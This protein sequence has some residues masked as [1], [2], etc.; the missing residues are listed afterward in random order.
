MNTFYPIFLSLAF[1]IPFSPVGGYLWQQSQQLGNDLMQQSQSLSQ[2]GWVQATTIT[3]QVNG[4]FGEKYQ[5]ARQYM[6]QGSDACVQAIDHSHQVVQQEMSSSRDSLQQQWQ[7]TQQTLSHHWQA[8]LQ[9]VQ[10]KSL[11][12][13]HTAAESGE[14]LGDALHGVFAQGLLGSEAAA[15]DNPDPNQQSLAANDPE[16]TPP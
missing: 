9:T 1:L 16:P 5:G 2:Q 14:R 4:W 12:V 11:G 7:L 13:W 15:D 6:A 3:Q 10:S 8:G